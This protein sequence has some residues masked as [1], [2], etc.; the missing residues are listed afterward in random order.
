M[1]GV[2]LLFEDFKTQLKDAFPIIY[3]YMQK[4]QQFPSGFSH[5][6]KLFVQNQQFLHLLQSGVLSLSPFQEVLQ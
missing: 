2:T 5:L 1:L 6:H 4:L 3:F